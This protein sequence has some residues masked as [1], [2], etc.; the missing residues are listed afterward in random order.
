LKAGPDFGRFIAMTEQIK[1][2]RRPLFAWLTLTLCMTLAPVG[3]LADAASAMRQALDRANAQDWTA[4]QSAAQGAGQGEYE[5]FLS[6]R[7]DWPGMPLLKEK[8]EEAVARSDSPPR[9]LAYFG[10]DLPE[11]STG[12]LALIR[13]LR[14]TGRDTEAEAEAFRAWT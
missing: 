2:K 12:S 7:P 1:K 13:A 14:A 6:R 9:V 8:G 11:T 5:A 10:T 4:A 3:A